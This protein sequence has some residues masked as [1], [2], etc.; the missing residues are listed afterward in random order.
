LIFDEE[1]EDFK[2]NYLYIEKEV[3]NMENKGKFIELLTKSYRGSK[4][5][6]DTCYMNFSLQILFHNYE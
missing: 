4:N 5:I 1:E 3:N 6:G 2:N